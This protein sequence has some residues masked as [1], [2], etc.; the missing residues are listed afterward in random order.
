MIGVFGLIVVPGAGFA[1]A[2]VAEPAGN[3]L[4]RAADEVSHER[5]AAAT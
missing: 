2:L 3:Q 5:G 4:T 1:T